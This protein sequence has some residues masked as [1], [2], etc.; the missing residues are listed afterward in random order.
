ML[1]LKR[2]AAQRGQ[3]E[4]GSVSLWTGCGRAA[5]RKRKA[6]IDLWEKEVA[7]TSGLRKWFGHEPE[8]F[9]AFQ[10]RYRAELDRNPAV[11]P[12]LRGWKRSLQKAA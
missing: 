3:R 7:P 1:K 2:C 10:K 5:K 6:A 8:K 4:T 12:F 9:P 11:E